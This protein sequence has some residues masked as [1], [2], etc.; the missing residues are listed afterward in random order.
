MRKET[1]NTFSEGMVMD[2][3]P[4]TTPNNVLTNCLNG[5]ILT[6]NG[7]EYLLQNDMGNGRVESAYLPAGY[8]P[9]GVTEFGGIIYVVSYNPQLDLSQIGSFP[10]PERNITSDELGE[11]IKILKNEDFGFTNEHKEANVFY[12]QKDLCQDKLNPGDKFIVYSKRGDITGNAGRL[13][14]L[15]S[16]ADTPISPKT[17]L[18]NLSLATI[19]EEGKIVKLSRLIKYEINNGSYKYIIP[20]MDSNPDETPNIDSYRTITQSPYNVFNSKVSGKLL[21]IAELLTINDFNVFTEVEFT[22]NLTVSHL[23]DASI[24]VTM[25]YSTSD[26]NVHL[27]AVQGK[28]HINTDSTD[29]PFCD[30]QGDSVEADEADP[31]YCSY[32]WDPSPDTNVESKLSNSDVEL[33][34]VSDYNIATRDKY[35]IFWELTPCMDFGPISYLKRSGVIELDKVGTGYTAL[36]EWRYF[37]DNNNIILSWALQSYP[38]PGYKVA[39]VRFIMST[40]DGKDGGNNVIKTLSYRVSDKRSYNGSF[41]ETIP[42]DVTYN[43]FE[44][45]D[46]PN[47][48]NILSK[49]KLYFVTIEVQYKKK[50]GGDSSTYKYFHRYLYTTD[51]FNKD[52]VQQLVPDFKVLKPSL[53][54]SID[55][56]EYNF[57]LTRQFEPITKLGKLIS[58]EQLQ[59]DR[60]TMCIKQIHYKEDLNFTTNP[61]ITNNY[62][63]FSLD[64]ADSIEINSQVE[65]KFIDFGD[66]KIA[67]IGQQHENYEEWLT[68]EEDTNYNGTNEE[69]IFNSGIDAVD[70]KW[71]FAVGEV[72]SDVNNNHNKKIPIDIVQYI[73]AFA[74]LNKKT[75]YFKGLIHPLAYNKSTFNKY[76]LEYDNESEI[77]KSTFA[78]AFGQYERERH[79]GQ[80]WYYEASSDD[81]RMDAH[82]KWGNNI[83]TNFY[84]DNIIKAMNTA[85]SGVGNSTINVCI[86]AYIED[87]TSYMTPYKGLTKVLKSWPW[88]PWKLI[89]NPGASINEDFTPKTGPGGE[90]GRFCG[91]DYREWDRV[92]AGKN[93]GKGWAVGN[94]QYVNKH[95]P[96]FIFIKNKNGNWTP[97][98]MVSKLGPGFGVGQKR[99]N[100]GTRYRSDEHHMNQLYFYD[101]YGIS[102]TYQNHVYDIEGTSYVTDATAKSNLQIAL[103]FKNIYT[104]L[105]SL[106]NQFYV[107]DGQELTT[108]DKYIPESIYYIRKYDPS[109]IVNINSEIDA[110]ADIK[111]SIIAGNSEFI[112]NPSFKDPLFN[113]NK[114]IVENDITIE[115]QL[116]GD[117]D[118]IDYNIT[119]DYQTQSISQSFV[120]YPEKIQDDLHNLIDQQGNINSLGTKI[121]KNTDLSGNLITDKTDLRSDRLY[122]LDDNN[123]VRTIDDE[124]KFINITSWEIRDG[125]YEAKYPE[126]KISLN[127]Q[128][129]KGQFGLTDDGMLYLEN[130]HPETRMFRAEV[131]GGGDDGSFGNFANVSPVDFLQCWENK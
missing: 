20:E 1:L 16:D 104:V 86:Y 32:K 3:N 63:I 36:S 24:K 5:T 58:D 42:F 33:C 6:Y 44:N 9:V 130:T 72:S 108:E 15:T 80:E 111:F 120:D 64:Q 30:I 39:G 50:D 46:N 131:G 128:S 55:T 100:D 82:G 17:R 127:S 93:T 62:N 79:N 8:V 123:Q 113:S 4:L 69:L 31:V 12:V 48:T 99:A 87:K 77:F 122:Y 116:V 115:A 70:K 84:D 35:D 92:Y 67:F 102:S 27:F 18:V 106:L 124:F 14:G 89:N 22:S 88:H 85:W 59:D 121:L 38:E 119:P 7:N 71:G 13:T 28:V 129:M 23:K 83:S 47:V 114:V 126:T 40:Y 60:E 29:P 94:R 101:V 118:V 65:S 57:D 105:A 49:N 74:H 95:T 91:T 25:E 2:L 68:L 109:Y 26:N 21:L 52:Y 90:I 41:T 117:T 53:N 66:Y 75:L 98:N 112:L 54:V 96:I 10:S 43:K 11:T 103:Q 97:I 19:T 56:S 73:K 45:L 34:S 61:Y 76:N 37:I 125:N 110:N 107:Y 78:S 51:I 81:L